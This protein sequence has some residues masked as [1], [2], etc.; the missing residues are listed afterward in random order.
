M[1][2][3][4]KFRQLADLDGL[5]PMTKKEFLNQFPKQ[6]LKD[7]EI[8]PIR[9]ELEKK[10]KETGKIDVNKLNSNEPIEVETHVAADDVDAS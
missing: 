5:N 2:Q 10:F 8:I 4:P 9:E 1:R 7:G 6:V 3:D